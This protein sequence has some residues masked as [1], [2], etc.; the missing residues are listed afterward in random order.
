MDIEISKIAKLPTKFGIFQIQS[1]KEGEKEHL[2]IFKGDLKG[3]VN[4][5]IHSEC[6]TG[7]TLSSLKCDCGEQLDFA[8]RYIQENGGLIIYLR[9]EGRGIGLLN[10]INAYSL[11]DEGLDTVEANLKLGFKEDERRYDVVNFILKHYKISSVNLMTNNPLK[12]KSLGLEVEL[13]QR[14]P[15]KI[16]SNDFNKEYLRIKEEKMG[17]LT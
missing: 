1:F 15:I 13:K 6:I 4:I 14:I 2:C 10:K 16:Q 5:R 8:L 9:Q 12:I 17:H 11:Q 3:D 7:D